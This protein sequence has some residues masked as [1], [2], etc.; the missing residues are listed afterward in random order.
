MSIRT[1]L[2]IN[3]TVSPR[4]IEVADPSVSL[5]I[6]DLYDT[7]RDKAAS[8]EAMGYDE[9]IDGSGKDDLGGGTLVGLTIKLFNAKVKFANKSSPTVCTIGGG[10]LVAVDANGQSMSPIEPSANVSVVVAQ[11]SSATIIETGVSG[12]TSAESE[13]LMKTLTT[14]KFIALR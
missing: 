14:G 6:Q 12:L 10:N 1:D 8:D 4:I 5:T 11:S 9:I 2:T 7:L 13:Q 3:W